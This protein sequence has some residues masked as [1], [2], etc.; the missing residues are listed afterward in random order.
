MFLLQAELR[1]QIQLQPL[2]SSLQPC[3]MA[4]FLMFGV[5]NCLIQFPIGRLGDTY[6]AYP[7]QISDAVHAQEIFRVI[8]SNPT[9]GSRSV[10][11]A[12]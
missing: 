5:N 12:C 2:L 4:V 8:L 10:A 1:L 9:G 11:E 6:V 7:W 3:S